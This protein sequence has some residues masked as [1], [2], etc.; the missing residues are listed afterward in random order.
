MAVD[1]INM[2]NE[3]AAGRKTDIKTNFAKFFEIYLVGT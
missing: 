1:Y 3:M 2:I